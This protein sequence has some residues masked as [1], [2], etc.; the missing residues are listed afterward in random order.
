[1]GR[2]D[3]NSDNE[4]KASLESK[5]VGASG[6]IAW[7]GPAG[8]G[9]VLASPSRSLPEQANWPGPLL[10]GHTHTRTMRGGDDAGDLAS[11]AFSSCPLDKRAPSG[12]RGDEEM[13]G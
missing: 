6:N 2:E 10:T 1:M 11:L 7:A 8:K 13:I 4:K 12:K 9:Y 3:V 5:R